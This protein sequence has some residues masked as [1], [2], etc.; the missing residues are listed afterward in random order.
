MQE[1]YR[2]AERPQDQPALV[3]IDELDAHMHPEWQQLLVPTLKVKFP[4]LQ[5]LATTHSPLVVLSTAP[6][7]I[8]K[9]EREGRAP[10]IQGELG[11]VVRELLRVR[12]PS[13]SALEREQSAARVLE[14]I[15]STQPPVAASHS[16]DGGPGV[17]RVRFVTEKL[18]GLT[19]AQALT[20]PLD[21]LSARDR[22]S[23]AIYV[24]YTELAAK[25]NRTDEEQ[26][27]LRFLADDLKV[28]KP[29]SNAETAEA[30][31]ASVA[32]EEMIQ[33]QFC[34]LVPPRKRSSWMK[35]SSSSRNSRPGR[36]GPDD[37][38]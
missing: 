17:V 2:D 1:I 38:P 23:A 25:P 10:A 35:S 29:P 16:A 15:R 13:Q 8:V 36:G 30:R 6:G 14:G 9:L 28:K 5:I 26:E 7:E 33:N 18:E 27:V 3:L 34:L 32:I 19:A 37:P 11:D 12:K 24:L 21:L 22:R 31:K 20:G 4:K